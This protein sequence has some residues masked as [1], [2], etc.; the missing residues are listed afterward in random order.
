MANISS[1]NER[2]IKQIIEH[3][4]TTKYS[5]EALDKYVDTSFTLIRP[6]GNPLDFKGFKEMSTSDTIKI[7]STKLISINKLEIEKDGKMGYCCFTEHSQFNFKGTENN[8][9]AVL[10]AVFK[11]DNDENWKII[12]MQRS[13]GRKPDEPL[14]KF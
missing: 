7:V 12:F 1:D 2:S 5:A 11:K 8:D 9:I 3:L 10:S 14:P 13:T 4:T 6:S